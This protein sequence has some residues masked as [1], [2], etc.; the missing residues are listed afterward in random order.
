MKAASSVKDGAA[1]FCFPT[2]GAGGTKGFTTFPFSN[3]VKI[4]LFLP[5][6]GSWSRICFPGRENFPLGQAE[7]D[8]SPIV[9]V[10]PHRV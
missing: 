5:K 4:F 9:F 1:S 6:R 7:N 8:A 2:T 3:F 10:T